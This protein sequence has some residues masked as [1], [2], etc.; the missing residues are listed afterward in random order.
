[1]RDYSD[2]LE[3]FYESCTETSR[4]AISED[5]AE[6]F[7]TFIN[8]IKGKRF[9][10]LKGHIT[11]PITFTLGLKD[12]QGRYVYFDEELREIVSMLLQA[13]AR[14]QVDMLKHHA[15]KVIIFIDE[16]ILSALGSSSYLGVSTDDVSRLISTLVA[17]IENAGGI[18]G[19]HCCGRAD[20]SMVI[21]SGPEILNFDAYD[22]LDPL[23]IYHGA[24]NQLLQRGGYLAWGIVPTSDSVNSLDEGQ[25]IKLL[26]D[27]LEKMY[28][29]IPAELVNSRILLTPSCGTGLRSTEEAVKI[30]QLLMRLR[31]AM[32]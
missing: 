7:H 6:G 12:N 20:W 18:A 11:G 23:I 31:E 25:I 15:E 29:H 2:E 22:Y 8:M 10:I 16:P 14:W 3:R 26:E 32:V 17:A 4:I 13:K 27:S 5:F 1:M 30:F 28:R 21:D 9:P 24:I 19:I